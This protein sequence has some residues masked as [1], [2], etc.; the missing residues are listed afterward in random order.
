MTRVSCIN[1]DARDPFLTHLEPTPVAAIAIPEGRIRERSD[2][3]TMNSSDAK[4]KDLCALERMFSGEYQMRESSS[5]SA[6]GH[7]GAVISRQCGFS[8]A[9]TPYV[10]VP[11]LRCHPVHGRE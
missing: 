5:A 4:A 2:A 7:K 11:H 6:G 1:I 3:A 8:V 9:E 10:V